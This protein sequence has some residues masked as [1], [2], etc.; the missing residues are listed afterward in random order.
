MLTD[1]HGKSHLPCPCWLLLRPPYRRAGK[2]RL[3]AGRGRNGTY[4]MLSADP[5]GDNKKTGVD[6][7]DGRAQMLMVQTGMEERMFWTGI[8]M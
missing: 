1:L 4:E 2:H 3:V 7:N 5:I 8:G 6:G